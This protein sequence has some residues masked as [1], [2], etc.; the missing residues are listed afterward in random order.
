MIKVEI[1]VE[2]KPPVDATHYLPNSEYDYECW[3]KE[4]FSMRVGSQTEWVEDHES[5]NDIRKGRALKIV[6]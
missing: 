5:S 2:V 3:V 6:K 4:G 1:N